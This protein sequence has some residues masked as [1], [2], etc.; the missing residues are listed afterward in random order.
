[1]SNIET[2]NHIDDRMRIFLFEWRHRVTLFKFT[3]GIHY[4]TAVLRRSHHRVWDVIFE[5]ESVEGAVKIILSTAPDLVGIH[6]YRETE[7]ETFKI[8]RIIKEKKPD[9]AII[10]GGHTATLYSTMI[11]ERESSIDFIVHGEGELTILELCRRLQRGKSIEGCKGVVYRKNGVVKRNPARELIKNLDSLPLPSLDVFLKHS[12]SR[13]P[14][15]FTALST[16]RGCRGK[17]GFCVTHRV[18]NHPGFKRWRGRTPGNIIKE[19][20]YLKN[21]FPDKRIVVR[22]VDGSFEDPDPK[23]K[24]RLRRII[25]LVEEQQL[26][27]AFTFLTRA[28]SWTEEDDS[29]LKRL[30]PLGLYMVAIGYEGST[31][32]AL[33]DLNKQT[34]IE[35]NYRV[36]DLFSRHDIPIFGFLIMFHPYTSLAQLKKNADFL[37]KM[38]IGYQPQ[39][40]W[41]EL[42]LWPD[43]R[44]F[45]RVVGDGLLLGPEPSG[46]QY[47]FSFKDGRVKKIHEALQQIRDSREHLIYRESIE[48]IKLEILLYDVWKYQ[49][50]EMERIK[51]I[52]EE[53][54]EACNENCRKVGIYQRKLFLSLI[55]GLETGDFEHKKENILNEWNDIFLGNHK[56]LEKVWMQFRMRLGRQKIILI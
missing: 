7:T 38:G 26:T 11:M 24:T 16:S 50:R 17:C 43:S 21:H 37:V 46:Y 47:R 53:Y 6:F 20:K 41:S 54:R 10:L 27:F 2:R 44:I 29:L 33:D 13:S 12:D 35:D 25:D 52:M 49:Y 31:Q 56:H 51:N 4:L 48:K 9:T 28:D 1:M 55:A 5:G 32:Q 18:F 39:A 3:Q 19:I 45:P 30:K 40:W 8:A 23:S 15:V 22:I 42:Y 14:C 34:T 36:Y